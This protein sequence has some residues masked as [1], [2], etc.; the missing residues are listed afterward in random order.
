MY[1][2]LQHM[3][4]LPGTF[5][6]DDGKCTLF[7]NT[8]FQSDVHFDTYRQR[9]GAL[10]W[11]MLCAPLYVYTYLFRILLKIILRQQLRYTCPGFI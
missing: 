7:S 5:N 11:R 9:Q 6:E 4:M 1:E 10:T 8:R 2:E 3:E